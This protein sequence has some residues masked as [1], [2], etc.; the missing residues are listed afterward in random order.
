MYKWE[1]QLIFCC[2]KLELIIIYFCYPQIETCDLF[3]LSICWESLWISKSNRPFSSVIPASP[4]LEEWSLF[5]GRGCVLHQV[6]RQTE[7]NENPLPHLHL[8]SSIY[9]T[10]TV[11]WVPNTYAWFQNIECRYLQSSKTFKHSGTP[12]IPWTTPVALDTGALKLSCWMRLFIH[13]TVIKACIN[14]LTIQRSAL[15]SLFTW[16]KMAVCLQY[17]FCGWL[18]K[19][20]TA[21]AWLWLLFIIL[22]I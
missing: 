9:A 18:V 10:W 19:E 15:N 1:W 2:W 11:Y 16:A 21:W 3:Y 4:C 13:H 17:A 12:S 6:R 7:E 8:F 5:L 20:V 14:W 22:F